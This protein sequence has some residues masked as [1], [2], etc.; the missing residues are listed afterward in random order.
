MRKACFFVRPGS[1]QLGNQ[2]FQVAQME[3]KMKSDAYPFVALKKR[4]FDYGVDLSTQD[5]NDPTESEFLIC[6]DQPHHLHTTFKK[7]EHVWILVISEPVIYAS[8]SWN[9]TNHTKFDFVFTYDRNLVDGKKYRH[10]TFAIDTDFFSFPATVNESVFQQRKLC[11][12]VSSAMQG[13]PDR[14][15]RNSLLYARY[16]AAKW[17][18]KYHPHDLEFYG[19]YFE[20]KDFHFS[21]RGVSLVKKILPAGWF[22]ALAKIWQRKLRRVYKGQLAPMEKLKK[23]SEYNFYLCYENI[24]GVDGYLT[25]K[26]F[27]CFYASC[28]PVYWGAPN[29]KE[30]IPYKCYIDG[31]AFE[32][33]E[34]LHTFIKH[35]SFETYQEYLLE[36]RHFLQSASLQKFTVRSFVDAVLDPI[37]SKLQREHTVL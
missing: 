6:L 37:R 13:M 2:I 33:F 26:I 8:E 25:E 5:I 14:L 18:G 24:K 19:Q 32:N 35:M 17:F 16:Q 10:Y 4:L 12:F 20:K 29:V 1:W 34:S 15:N 30:L 3:G 21:F 9:K 27:D 28:V 7:E 23:I 22:H 36:A 11:T 31:Q